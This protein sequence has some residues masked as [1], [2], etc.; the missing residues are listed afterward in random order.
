MP[1]QKSILKV[2]SL[3]HWR[4]RA[5]KLGV[6]IPARACEKVASE[7]RLGGGLRMWQL[8]GGSDRK[9][10]GSAFSL[11][12]TEL[13]PK[14]ACKTIDNNLRTLTF[15][16]LSYLK[17]YQPHFSFSGKRKMLFGTNTYKQTH[18]KI[19]TLHL[20]HLIKCI[21]FHACINS[22]PNVLNS[23]KLRWVFRWYD[24]LFSDISGGLSSPFVSEAGT[25]LDGIVE[26][27]SNLTMCEFYHVY[28]YVFD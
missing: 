7:Y 2:K 4:N 18:K 9:S 23:V 15:K 12:A 28:S 26:A 25:Y 3:W 17:Y 24:T 5:L 19:Q 14:I 22:K 8:D 21:S 6:Q 10:G 11:S 13:V 1:D 27:L 16:I 20:S